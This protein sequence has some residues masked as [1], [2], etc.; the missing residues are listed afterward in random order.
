M[1]LSTDIQIKPCKSSGAIENLRYQTNLV[2]FHFVFAMRAG[3][4]LVKLT[5]LFVIL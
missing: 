2:L 4:S 5:F 1:K 3:N